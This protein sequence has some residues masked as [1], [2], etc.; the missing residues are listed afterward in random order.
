MSSYNAVK[1]AEPL[2][3]FPPAI[4]SDW[5]CLKNPLDGIVPAAA[6]KIEFTLAIDYTRSR[7]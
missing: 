4:Q 2:I 3:E 6:L 7:Y 1:H 5:E